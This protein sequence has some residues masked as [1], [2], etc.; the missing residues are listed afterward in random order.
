MPLQTASFFLHVFTEFAKLKRDLHK[1]QKF[2]GEFIE[3]PE[4][5]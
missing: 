3:C 5:S 1:A 2:K 4:T